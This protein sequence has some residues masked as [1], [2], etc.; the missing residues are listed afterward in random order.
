MS[1]LRWFRDGGF[2]LRRSEEYLRY[3]AECLELASVL[4]VPRARA[5]LH[6]MAQVWLRLA[7]EVE[8]RSPSPQE[9]EVS[10]PD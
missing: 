9:T 7:Q 4:R 3:A 1:A 6:H 10:K 8:A 2:P 5:A